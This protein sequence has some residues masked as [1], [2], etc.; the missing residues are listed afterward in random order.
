MYEV[1]DI[2]RLEVEKMFSDSRRCESA[3][4]EMSVNLGK[5]LSFLSVKFPLL[6]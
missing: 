4:G 2:S 5:M 6:T 3:E 1:S